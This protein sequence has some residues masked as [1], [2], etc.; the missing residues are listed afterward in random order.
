MMLSIFEKKL[1]NLHFINVFMGN[2]T[3]LFIIHCLLM[4]RKPTKTMQIIFLNI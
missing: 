3:K 1:W 4:G 2:K